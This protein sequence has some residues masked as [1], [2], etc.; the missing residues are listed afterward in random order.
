MVYESGIDDDVISSLAWDAYVR[1]VVVL[2]G[3]Q[4]GG[5]LYTKPGQ[6]TFNKGVTGPTVSNAKNVHKLPEGYNMPGDGVAEGIVNNAMLQVDVFYKDA[7]AR[8]RERIGGNFLSQFLHA[9]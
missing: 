3:N 2:F 7:I 1:T 9:G 6:L 5:K 8:I 4:H